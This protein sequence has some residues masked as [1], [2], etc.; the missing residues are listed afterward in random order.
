M[1]KKLQIVIMVITLGIFLMPTGVFA[2]INFSHQSEEN[3]CSDSTEKTSSDCC[4]NHKN[5]D[6]KKKYC[7][8]T[9]GNIS[10][11]CPPTTTLPINYSIIS[12][13]TNIVVFVTF[14]NLWNYSKQQPKSIYFQIWSPPKLS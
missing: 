10:C 6:N 2:H 5:Q 12:E 11:H 4:K 7:D 1:A 14:K 8:G 9:C 3:C 13:E